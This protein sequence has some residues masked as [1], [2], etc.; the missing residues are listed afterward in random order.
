MDLFLTLGTRPALV[1]KKDTC[2][3]GQSRGPCVSHCS[4]G[5]LRRASPPRDPPKME[6]SFKTV[7]NAQSRTLSRP[8]RLPLNVAISEEQQ[9]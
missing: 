5:S 2:G 3:H 1:A 4:S 6:P 7:S 9:P 8:Y